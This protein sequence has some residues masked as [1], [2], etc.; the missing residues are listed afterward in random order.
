MIMSLGK[1]T[2]I[3][4]TFAAAVCLSAAGAGAATPLIYSLETLGGSAS[5]GWDVNDSGQAT[6]W[7]STALDAESHAYRYDGTPGAGGV[8]RDLLTLGGIRSYGYGI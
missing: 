7:A 6:G 4:L 5:N 3:R 2:L 1:S 8:M